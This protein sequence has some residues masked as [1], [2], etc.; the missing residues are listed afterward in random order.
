MASG[1]RVARRRRNDGSGFSLGSLLF[2]VGLIG[3]LIW[4]WNWIDETWIGD[5]DSRI[6]IYNSLGRNVGVTLTIQR[7]GND[8]PIKAVSIE[9]GKGY[10]NIN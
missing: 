6:H 2:W 8:K 3:G 1:S 9:S 5:A 7:S 4:T 10:T